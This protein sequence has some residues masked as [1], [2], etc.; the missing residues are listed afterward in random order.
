[1]C[2][3]VGIPRWDRHLQIGVSGCRGRQKTSGSSK[4]PVKAQVPGGP[5]DHNIR[6]SQPGS[7]HPLLHRLPGDPGEDSVQEPRTWRPACS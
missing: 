6:L 7:W 5:L 1:M 4:K 2:Y 3:R